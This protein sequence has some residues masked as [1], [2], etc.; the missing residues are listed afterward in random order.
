[1]AQ[2]VTAVLRLFQEAQ[3]PTAEE[4]EAV[5]QVAVQHHPEVLAVAV[6]VGLKTDQL[7]QAVLGL[8]I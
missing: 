1:V 4:E 2:V 7:K 8:L 6:L 3:L 5:A